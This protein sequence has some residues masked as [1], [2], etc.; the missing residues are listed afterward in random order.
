MTTKAH[1]RY[2][3]KS[4][5]LVPGVTTVLNLLAKPALIY[6]AWDLGMKGEDFKKVRDKAADIG[7]V[8]H[9]LIECDIKGLKPDLGDFSPNVVKKALIAFEAFRNWRAVYKVETVDCEC[10]LVSEKYLY[11]GTIDWVARDNTGSLLL[12]DVKTSKGIYDEMRYQLAAY[13]HVWDEN[14]PDMPIRK[15]AIIKLSKETADFS[16]HPF[17]LL[18]TEFRIFLHLR[19]VYALRKLGDRNRDKGRPYRRMVDKYTAEQEKKDLKL[20][21]NK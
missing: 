8:A 14:H 9:Y 21:D 5:V 17:V 1:I 20:W 10:G 2:R 13:W 6:W 3:T 18:D 15:A 19:D 7:T 11:G 12:L 4:G 16:F